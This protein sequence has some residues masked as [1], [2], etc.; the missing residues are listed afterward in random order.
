MKKLTF[1]IVYVIVTNTLSAQVKVFSGGNTIVGSTNSPVS[2]AKFQVAGPTIFT[3]ATGTVTPSYAAYIRS[4]NGVSTANTPDYTWNIDNTTGIFHPASNTIGITAGG[5]EKLRINN[6]GQIVF[7]T[8]TGSAGNPSIAWTTDLTTG[9]FHPTGGIIGFS[10]WSLEKMRVSSNGNLLIGT[11]TDNNNSKLY[12]SAVTD[13]RGFESITSHNSDYLYNQINYVNRNYSKAIAVFNSITGTPTETFFVYGIGNV[14]CAGAYYTSDRSLKENFDTLSGSLAKVKQ[15]HGL[16]Y[17]FKSSYT[18]VSSPKREIGFIA[19]DVEA[20]FPELVETN[21][22]GMKGIAYQN[23]TAVLVEAIKEQDKKIEL[24]QKDLNT[25]CQKKTT[26]GSTNRSTSIIEPEAIKNETT[27]WLAQNKPNPFNKETVI[28]YNI[29]QEGKGSILIFDMNGKLLK[30][31]PVKIPG[32]G[33]VTITA[34]DLAAGMYY[35]TLVVND[36]E[37]DTKKMI[38]TQ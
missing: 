33:S 35:Y 1:L 18:G 6:N 26:I 19:Q 2:G 22:K 14:W 17:N 5:S 11:T 12:V 15:L 8:Y 37:V 9:I 29:V 13:K 34:N 3:T 7:N 30:T 20:I 32:K 38:L 25:C 16:Y 28:E 31:I 27:N 21:D 36:N 24:L 10:I 4:A 23:L